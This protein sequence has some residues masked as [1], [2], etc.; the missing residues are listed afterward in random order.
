MAIDHTLAV[1]AVSDFDTSHDWYRRFFGT[2][3]TNVPMPGSLAEW[4]T[5]DTGWIQM[6][7]APEHAGHSLAN[8]AVDDIGRFIATL[9][10]RGIETGEIIDANKGVQICSIDDPDGNTITLIGNFRTQY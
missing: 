7:H 3:A 8:I 9:L 10:E 6:F 5:T 4:R 1:V 2:E